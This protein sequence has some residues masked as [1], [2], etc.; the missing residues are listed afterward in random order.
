MRRSWFP[1]PFTLVFIECFLFQALK[2]QFIFLIGRETD[3]LGDVEALGF[4]NLDLLG[5]FELATFDQVHVRRRLS[6]F[7]N[8]LPTLVESGFEGILESGEGSARPTLQK[9]QLL[10]EI[11][12]FVQVFLLY[13]LKDFGV[14]RL[15]H[16]S[17]VAVLQALD[18]GGPGLVLDQRQLAEALPRLQLHHLHEQRLLLHGF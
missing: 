1:I 3:E 2:V 10:Q 12:Y 6:F 16:D 9:G 4:S 14:V 7:E 5:D 8:K 11:H 18:G 13:P 15:G 17:E